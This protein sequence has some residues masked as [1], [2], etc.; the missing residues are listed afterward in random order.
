LSGI[1]ISSCIASS[2]KITIIIGASIGAEAFEIHINNVMTNPLS[3][4]PTSS[5]TFESY[6]TSGALID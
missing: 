4:T 3:T 6:G 5:F 1:T 2:R